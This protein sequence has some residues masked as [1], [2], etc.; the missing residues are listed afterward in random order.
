MKTIIR[1]ICTKSRS[2]PEDALFKKIESEQEDEVVSFPEQVSTATNTKLGLRLKE[3]WWRYMYII[4]VVQVTLD[5]E[6]S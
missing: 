2:K 6:K 5:I 1:L 4:L 3:A